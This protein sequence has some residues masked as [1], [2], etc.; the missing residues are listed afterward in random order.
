MTTPAPWQGD[1]PAPRIK[2]SWRCLAA[3]PYRE[4]TRETT[5][6]S[7]SVLVCVSCGGSDLADRVRVRADDRAGAT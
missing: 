4:E 1:H 7:L 6:G 2:H 5:N 3:G